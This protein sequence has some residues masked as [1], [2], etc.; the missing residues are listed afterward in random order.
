MRGSTISR[1]LLC[2]VLVASMAGASPPLV[3][4]ACN[5]NLHWLNPL[6]RG[7]TLN[8]VSM[9]SADGEVAYAVGN[10]GATIK[11]YDGGDNWVQKSCP[12]STDLF[13]VSFIDSTHGWAAG[14]GGVIL[15]M[16]D[17]ASYQQQTS[18]T[19]SDVY[20]IFFRSSTLGWACTGGGEVLRTTDGGTT[21]IPVDLG[22]YYFT[23]VYFVS[24]TKG[25]V[26]SA[27]GDIFV[28]TD[29][30]ATWPTH[31][32]KGDSVGF[33]DISFDPDDPQIGWIASGTGSPWKTADGGSTWNTVAD[34]G[35]SWY[36][37]ECAGGGSNVV[38]LGGYNVQPDH[39]AKITDGTTPSME[40]FNDSE[41]G[42]DTSL[43]G[44]DCSS[45]TKLLAVGL[46]GQITFTEDG[47][48][49]WGHRA[50]KA[51]RDF[52]TAIQFVDFRTGY[53][54][55]G[56]GV[57]KSTNAGTDW[58]ATPTP[59]GSILYDLF[60]I[61]ANTGWAVGG[62][63]RILKTVNGGTS[64]TTQTSGVAD[65]LTAVYFTDATHGWAA[66]RNGR[67]LWTNTGGTTW[68]A[69]T[70]GAEAFAAIDFFGSDLG[71]VVGSNGAV[72]VT[73][74]GS[75][76]GG[77]WIAGGSTGSAGTLHLDAVDYAAA[78]ALYIGGSRRTILAA[79]DATMLKSTNGGGAWGA[80]VPADLTKRNEFMNYG[81]V[82]AMSF[83]SGT[84]GWVALSD[85]SV[86]YTTDSGNTWTYGTAM[87]TNMSDI[88]VIGGE[89][90]WVC[91][92]NG[93]VMSNY[94]YETTKVYR[95]YN[96]KNGTHFYTASYDEKINIIKTWPDIYKYEGVGYEYDGL[97]ATKPLYRFYNRVTGSHFYTVSAEEANAVIAKWSNVY[98]FEGP[99]YNVSDTPVAGGTVYRFYNLKNGSHFFTASPDERDMVIATWPNVFRYEGEAYYLPM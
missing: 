12:V 81:S 24:A 3:A 63:G 42:K 85:G 59:A 93:R 51:P 27:N 26:I 79:G 55:A 22:D 41:Y 28:S 34:A 6:P 80:L 77:T 32:D 60:F 21:W 46:G 37:V 35:T 76:N 86:A 84:T 88:S 62:S 64:W 44:I 50:Q 71:A 96:M 56:D 13:A 8:A 43:Y 67:L 14:Q 91:A 87:D 92:S 19:S 48:A 5:T 78:N 74:N 97:K 70:L 2:T 98:T 66:G 7:E 65:Q 89:Y 39:I 4:S 36:S 69:T 47:G 29:G 68:N 17:G 58:A 31:I 57:W 15:K 30:G 18:N 52:L 72:Y 9:A 82:T 16:T 23:E 94:W 25:F 54:C 10:N 83:S 40:V 33:D 11:T 75:T 45:G 61:D 99:A 38:W 49:T 90:I 73:S 53:L 95:F 20:G 1:I